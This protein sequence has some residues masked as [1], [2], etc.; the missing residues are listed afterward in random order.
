MLG[1][2]LAQLI[3]RIRL[4]SHPSARDSFRFAGEFLS[5]EGMETFPHH[6]VLKKIDM[7]RQ[8]HHS[9]ISASGPQKVKA[10][11]LTTRRL[12]SKSMR[13]VSSRGCHSHGDPA[14]K[15]CGH[16]RT[17]RMQRKHKKRH[18]HDRCPFIP[19][20]FAASALPASG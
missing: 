6:F 13:F 7:A 9:S 18:C 5:Q 1:I 3:T 14:C 11:N 8:F 15:F 4:L 2:C 19:P 20:H 12:E 16:W 10:L 17:C